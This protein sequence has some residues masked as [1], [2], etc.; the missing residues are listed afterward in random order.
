[1]IALEYATIFAA[2]GVAVTVASRGAKESILPRLDH[3]LRDALMT[4]LETRGVEILTHCSIA[5][6]SGKEGVGVHLVNDGNPE[7]RSF[8]AVLSAVG[9][10]PVKEGLGLET[11]QS[12]EGDGERPRLETDGLHR[13]ATETGSVYA[14]GDVSGSGLACRAVVQCPGRW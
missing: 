12:K 13:L 7:H 1:M 14:V 4:E 6:E 5:M 10:V 11:L 8:E 3:A 9:R 2:M